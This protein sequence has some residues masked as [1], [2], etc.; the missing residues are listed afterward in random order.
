MNWSRRK[1]DMG[2]GREREWKHRESVQLRALLKWAPARCLLAMKFE[3]CH[4]ASVHLKTMRS[5]THDCK[6]IKLRD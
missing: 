5:C 3:G 4:S 2:R 1:G 6:Q